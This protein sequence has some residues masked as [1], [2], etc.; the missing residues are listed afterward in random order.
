MTGDG[1]IFDGNNQDGVIGYQ[2]EYSTSTFTPGDGTAT[3]YE[4]DSFPHTASQTNTQSDEMIIIQTW[5]DNGL[6]VRFW[7]TTIC[8]V[9]LMTSIEFM[10]MSW[11]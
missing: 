10:I 3:V 1:A 2:I 4:F 6:K 7:T 9:I 5:S 8:Q 11:Y